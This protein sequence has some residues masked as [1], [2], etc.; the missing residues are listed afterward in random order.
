MG[1]ASDNP[2]R[3]RRAVI[4][5]VVNKLAACLNALALGEKTEEANRNTHVNSPLA[6][7]AGLPTCSEML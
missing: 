4:Q 1:N 3:S 7:A 6:I 5:G 2:S